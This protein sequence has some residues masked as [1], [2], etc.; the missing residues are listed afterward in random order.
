MYFFK[1]AV[2]ENGDSTFILQVASPWSLRTKLSVP[3][4]LQGP[5]LS[6]SY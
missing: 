6:D 2:I 4:V 5:S 1:W 3:A